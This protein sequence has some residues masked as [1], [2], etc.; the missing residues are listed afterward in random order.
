[1]RTLDTNERLSLRFLTLKLT[2]LLSL[3]SHSRV[4][5]LHSLSVASMDLHDSQCT[6]FPTTLL[7]HSRPSFLGEPLT[8]YRYPADESLCV[9]ATL[10]EYL[11]RRQSLTSSDQLLITYR[12]P[13]HPAHRDT[14]ARWLKTVLTLSGIDTN[15]FS[16]HSFRSAASSKAS[17]SS[18]PL[19]DILRHGQWRTERTWRRHYEKSLPASPDRTYAGHLLN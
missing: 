10:V 8:F 19:V 4:H 12:K 7:K 5:Y 6:F 11:R 15:L 1:M 2:A 17:A 9:I 13:H 14:I 18:V 16:A 3:L